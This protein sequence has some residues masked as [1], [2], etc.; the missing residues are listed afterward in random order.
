MP[1]GDSIH[2]SVQ[3]DPDLRTDERYGFIDSEGNFCSS[4]STTTSW[5]C[6]TP[7]SGSYA[8]F[9]DRKVMVA[10][11]QLWTSRLKPWKSIF[12]VCS[13]FRKMG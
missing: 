13:R 11:K 12:S 8:D 9:H 6:P 3:L 1:E 2:R 10:R 4:E 5:R 7:G